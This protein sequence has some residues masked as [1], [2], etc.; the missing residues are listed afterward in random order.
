MGIVFTSLIPRW[1]DL[2]V[3]IPLTSRVVEFQ[4]FTHDF[5]GVPS[6][7]QA[8]TPFSSRSK[9]SSIH[10]SVA[11][12]PNTRTAYYGASQ[13][14]NLAPGSPRDR[15]QY[16]NVSSPGDRRNSLSSPLVDLSPRGHASS[17]PGTTS[18]RPTSVHSQHNHTSPHQ[19]PP[20]YAPAAG[21]VPP[22][23]PLDTTSKLQSDAMMFTISQLQN[24][25][26]QVKNLVVSKNAIANPLQVDAC[27][28]WLLAFHL[29]HTCP[30]L[31]NLILKCCSSGL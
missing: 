3:R 6:P 30:S 11:A 9:Q 13:P 4:S 17:A 25:L 8:Y 5:A 19:Q 12:S 10:S 15:Q 23:Q 18:S 28:E 27:I 16:S 29:L 26:H 21:L 14:V 31:K 7:L 2:L 20:Y 1:N 22:T 24:D